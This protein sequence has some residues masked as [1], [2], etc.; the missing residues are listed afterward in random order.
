ML[1]QTDETE[2]LAR[3]LDATGDFRVLRRLVP[4]VPTPTPA[5]YDGKFGVIIDFE[6]TGLDPTRDEIIEVAA[7]KFRYSNS[8]EISGVAGVFQSFNEPSK[9]IPAEIVELTE[10]T[11]MMVAGHRIDAAAIEKFVSDD[12]KICISHNANFDR[13]WAES[14]WPIFEH[15]N[16]G[17]SMSDIDWKKTSGFGGAKLDYLLA[18]AGFFHGAHRAIDDCQAVLEILD[19][20]LP[21]QSATAFAKLLDHARRKTIRVWAQGAPFELK[22]VLKRRGYRWSDGSDGRPRS[23]YTD[24]DEDKRDAELKFLRQEIYQRDVDILCREITALDRFSN[25]V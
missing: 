10:I 16:W 1:N 23:W 13:K 4:R 3:Q 7:V 24:V 8:D 9:P 14:R 19:R 20:P 17:C 5:G 12:V 6:T 18:G 11:D 21:G 2:V 25:R 15:M 22:D